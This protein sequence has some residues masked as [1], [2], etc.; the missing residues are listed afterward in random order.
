MDAGLNGD[1]AVIKGLLEVA[2]RAGCEGLEKPNLLGTPIGAESDRPDRRR[3][4]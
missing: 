3:R 2:N 1:S 4:R